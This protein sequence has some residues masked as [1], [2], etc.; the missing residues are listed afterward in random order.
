MTG[1]GL[2]PRCPH[3]N[4]QEDC[5]ECALESLEAQAENERILQEWHDTYDA[6]DK[7]AREA[8]HR[9]VSTD[10]SEGAAEGRVVA[11]TVLLRTYGKPDQFDLSL[12]RILFLMVGENRVPCPECG[13]TGF[14][15]T[16]NMVTGEV[17]EVM[18]QLCHGHGFVTKKPPKF[19]VWRGGKRIFYDPRV[20]EG[21]D[22]N[23]VD[24]SEEAIIRR[25]KLIAHGKDE[26]D[27]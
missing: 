14:K 6:R 1:D 19:E 11:Y 20:K 21:G 9:D 18:C 27:D 24:G 16:I 5:G 10:A 12:S 26:A 2:G 23:V 4:F 25:E 8:L 7:A 13:M 3:G 17:V 15:E 22:V